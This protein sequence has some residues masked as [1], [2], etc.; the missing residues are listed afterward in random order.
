M[1]EKLLSIKELA[2]ELGR[3]RT[4]VWA[5]TRRGFKMPG[6]RASLAAA[7][8]WLEKHGSPCSVNKCEHP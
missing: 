5:M 8:K 4:Y 7:V 3:G 1:T 2:A 6:R